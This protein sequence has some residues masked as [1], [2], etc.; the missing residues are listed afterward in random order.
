M[1]GGYTTTDWVNSFPLTQPTTLDAQGGGRGIYAQQ[2]ATVQG[3]WVTNG[4]AGAQGGGLYAT[5]AMTVMQMVFYSN[6]ADTG[7]GAGLMLLAPAEVQNTLFLGNTA[8]VGGGAGWLTP[9]PMCRLRATPPP[10]P[11]PLST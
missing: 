8:N 6:T 3:L 1:I 10:A 7:G 4:M 11:G 2:P 5:Q 9:S